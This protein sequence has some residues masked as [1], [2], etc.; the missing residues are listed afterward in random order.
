[1]SHCV[2]VIRYV[3]ALKRKIDGNAVCK[4]FVERPWWPMLTGKRLVY[5]GRHVAVAD[6]A[7]FFWRV[8]PRENGRSTA[9]GRIHFPRNLLSAP[10]QRDS[11]MSLSLS[12]WN[13]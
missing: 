4:Q 10:R 3:G 9:F 11:T 13:T 12:A 5:R 2:G 8:S 6:F 7:V 1:M